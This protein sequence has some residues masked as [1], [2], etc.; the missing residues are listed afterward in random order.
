MSVGAVP[1]PSGIPGQLPAPM[2]KQPTGV[3]LEVLGRHKLLRMIGLDVDVTAPNWNTILFSSAKIR[4]EMK[5]PPQSVIDAIDQIPPD[6]LPGDAVATEADA[7]L[8]S[9]AMTKPRGQQPKSMVGG[10]RLP[11]P[12]DAMAKWLR[13]VWLIVTGP[14]A[15]RLLVAAG[16]LTPDDEQVLDTAY[17][18][19]LDA[20]KQAA[21]G[22]AIAL[23]TASARTGVEHDLPPWLNDQL[24]TLFDED[25]PTRYYSDIYAAEQ[26][27]AK[28]AAGLNP[29]SASPNLISV[30]SA[31]SI[32]PGGS[33][34]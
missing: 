10:K 19:G 17:P 32:T 33:I 16:Y 6:A 8:K 12:A 31:P 11:P 18:K 2:G 13:H 23:T 7:L 27:Q 28:P 3:E 30:Q 15:T 1:Q 14:D 5:A 26:A 25:R 34:K 9:L 20:E 29:S 24:L 22:A 21:V 4:L